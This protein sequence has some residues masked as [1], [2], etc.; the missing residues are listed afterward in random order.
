[1]LPETLDKISKFENK[2]HKHVVVGLVKKDN[3]KLIEAMHGDEKLLPD[4]NSLV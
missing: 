4:R 1:M 2:P 3:V